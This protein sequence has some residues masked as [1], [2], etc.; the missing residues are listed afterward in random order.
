MRKAELDSLVGVRV[1]GLL[2]ENQAAGLEVNGILEFLGRSLVRVAQT[3]GVGFEVNLGF[4]LGGDVSGLLVILEIGSIN[5]IEAGGVAAVERDFHIVKFGVRSPPELDCLSGTNGEHRAALLGFGDGEAGCALLDF[6]A[7]P[8]R[9]L[10]QRILHAVPRIE[11]SARD[12]QHSCN[13]SG[14][15]PAAQVG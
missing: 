6:E 13:S 11:V 14:A 9:D 3:F 15:E 12:Q 1:A 8:C 5:A 7:H 4:T 2:I 10:L